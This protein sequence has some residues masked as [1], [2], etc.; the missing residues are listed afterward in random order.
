MIYTRAI[1]AAFIGLWINLPIIYE[2]HDILVAGSEAACS[3]LFIIE[4]KETNGHD[5]QSS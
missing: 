3:E 4:E 2:V 5:H 1:W